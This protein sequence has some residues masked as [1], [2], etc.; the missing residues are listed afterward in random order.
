M[1]DYLLTPERMEKLRTFGLHG[2]KISLLHVEAICMAQ[3]EWSMA[4]LDSKKL[5]EGLREIFRFHIGSEPDYTF[6]DQT[7]ALLKEGE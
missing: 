4:R 7:L 3:L 6:I 2:K 1:K 5:R